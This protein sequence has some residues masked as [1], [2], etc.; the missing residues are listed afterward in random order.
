VACILSLLFH[1]GSGKSIFGAHLAYA[2]AKL[3]RTTRNKT[4]SGKKK[5]VV[6]CG[7]SN[8]S[9]DVV[10]SKKMHKINAHILVNV[11]TLPSVINSCYLARMQS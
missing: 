8:I 1:V 2:F 3:N 10:A 7:S 9:V 11:C 4:I 6:Y 5:C